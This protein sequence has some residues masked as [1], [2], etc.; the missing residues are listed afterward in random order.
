MRKTA[1]LA[2]AALIAAGPALA[3]QNNFGARTFEVTITNI[4]PGQTFTPILAATHDSSIAFFEL[5]EPAIPELAV[6]AESGDV[7]PLSDLLGSVP[8]QVFDTA[9][10]GDLLGPGESVTLTIRATRRFNRLSLAGML[11][12]T[13]DTFVALDSRPLPRRHTTYTALGY[14]AGSE[15]DDE[16]CANIPGP[17]C[18]GGALSEEDG[19]GFVHV[20]NGVHGIGDLDPAVFDWRN[21]IARIS[22]S[23]VH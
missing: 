7:G 16:L 6:L 9:A 1:L 8:G 3:D 13:N 11:I 21:P 22:I 20:S 12:P 5:G 23:R 17:F 14:D 2:A 10:T 4:T 19:E 18:G 15:P